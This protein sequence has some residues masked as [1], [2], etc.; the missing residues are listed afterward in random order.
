MGLH[1]FIRH[2]LDQRKVKPLL[3]KWIMLVDILKE[4]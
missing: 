2:Y 1:T 3:G 4:I